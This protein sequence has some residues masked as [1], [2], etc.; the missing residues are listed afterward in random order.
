MKEPFRVIEREG[1]GIVR[2]LIR[3]RCEY[4]QIQRKLSVHTIPHSIKNELSFTEM[5]QIPFFCHM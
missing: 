2:F 4:L 5:L 1:Q 3:S